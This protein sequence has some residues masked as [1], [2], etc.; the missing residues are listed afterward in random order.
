MTNDPKPTRPDVEDLRC[1]QDNVYTID[2]ASIRVLCNYIIAL[3]RR[4]PEPTLDDGVAANLAYPNEGETLIDT[5]RLSERRAFIAGRASMRSPDS[6]E[7]QRCTE[8]DGTRTGGHG[9]WCW[10]CTPEGHPARR[11]HEPG[12]DDREARALLKESIDDFIAGA[13]YGDPPSQGEIEDAIDR[14]MAAT[15]R[16][17]DAALATVARLE[18]EADERCCRVNPCDGCIQSAIENSE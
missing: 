9:G 17:H 6:T 18:A 15:R 16:E 12:K 5:V 3:E 7:E 11:S 8:C 1:R 2:A 13:A 10:K 4:S 14:F